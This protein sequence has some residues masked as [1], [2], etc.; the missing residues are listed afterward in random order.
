LA[1]DVPPNF[2]TR[3]GIGLPSCR[4][5]APGLRGCVRKGKGTRSA[6][7]LQLGD[8]LGTT[9]QS[10]S[11]AQ[12]MQGYQIIDIER[13]GGRFE[14]YVS[15]DGAFREFYVDAATGKIIKVER[16]E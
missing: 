4:H 8:T 10:V 3:T 14:R 2:I 15:K 6:A 13:T 7:Q 1:T 11:E 5:N 12:T 9:V 16:A